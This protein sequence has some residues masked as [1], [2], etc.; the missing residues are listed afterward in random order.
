[1]SLAAPQDFAPR[2]VAWQRLHGRHGLPWQGTRDAYR[3]WLSEIMLQQTQVATVLRYY[4][5]FL[6]R[7]PTVA[8]LAQA[9]AD[10]V[11]ALWSGLGYYSRARHLHACAQAVVQSHGGVFPTDAVVLESLPGIGRSTAAAVAAFS[12]GQRGA[13]LDGNVKRVL[14]RH[15]AFGEDLSKPAGVRSLWALAEALLPSN[16]I[17]PYTQGLMDLGATVCTLRRPACGG[18]PVQADCAAHA[19]GRP[20]DFPVKTRRVQ[21][22]RRESHLLL[23]LWTAGAEG[24]APVRVEPQVLLEQRSPTGIWSGLWTLP[25][26]DD[27]AQLRQWMGRCGLEETAPLKSLAAVEHALTH[28]DWTLRPRAIQV[29][30]ARQA[31]AMATQPLPARA[32]CA[33]WVP[34]SEALKRGLPAPVRRLLEDVDAAGDRSVFADY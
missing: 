2:V 18:C 31:G 29:R 6:R 7:F 12:S 26:F 11:M 17:E 24:L 27:E 32:A 14:A 13:I 15:R 30:Q 33:R 1:M 34:L 21:R 3:I 28:L 19:L 22:G 20:Q 5:P 9:S 10:E 16:D 25:V 4:G 8:D 23:A